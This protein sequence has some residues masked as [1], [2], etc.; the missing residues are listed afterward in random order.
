MIGDYLEEAMHNEDEALKIY[1]SP[2][3]IKNNRGKAIQLCV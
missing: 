1:G 2:Y 3:N